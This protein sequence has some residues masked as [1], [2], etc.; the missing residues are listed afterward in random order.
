[1]QEKYLVQIQA[2]RMLKRLH[3]KNYDNLSVCLRLKHKKAGNGF[4]YV[5]IPA[6]SPNFFP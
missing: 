4:F 2:R 6:N 1:M 3:H 5:Y